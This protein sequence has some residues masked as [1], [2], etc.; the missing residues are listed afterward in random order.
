MSDKPIETPAAGEAEPIKN[1][2][3]EFDRKTAN[4]DAEAKALRSEVQA[5]VA[6]LKGSAQP[7]APETGKKISVFDDE[8]AYARQIE[9]RAEQR[10]EKKMAAQQERQAKYQSVSIQLMA[11]FPELGDKS[12]PLMQKAQEVFN[13][14]SEEDRAHPLAMKTA[15]YDAATELDVKPMNKRSRKEDDSF[16]LGSGSG[17]SSTNKNKGSSDVSENDTMLAQLLGVNIDDPKVRD[18]IAKKHGRK[19]YGKYE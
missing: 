19:S 18:R 16:A 6:Q 13:S 8:E 10:I 17:S 5:L 11:D 4:L 1:L 15:V 3:A 2:K 12:S 7:T 14:L 9:E